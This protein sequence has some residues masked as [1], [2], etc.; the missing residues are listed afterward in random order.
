MSEFK[1]VI[2]DLQEKIDVTHQ[3]EGELT[4]QMADLLARRDKLTAA[5]ESI[6]GLEGG[7]A[8]AR[9]RQARKPPPMDKGA[10]KKVKASTDP[11]EACAGCGREA[12]CRTCDA[13][14]KP[15]CGKCGMKAR[16]K[17]C[18][19][20]HGKEG[21]AP[22]KPAP[23]APAPAATLDPTKLPCIECNLPAKEQGRCVMCGREVCK[24]RC[25]KKFA[26][27]PACRRA[28]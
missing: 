9:G 22:K 12:K 17:T 6:H 7:D 19:E 13:C 3:E 16:A 2:K 21:K 14:E 1:S 10:P 15:K 28:P 27:C 18:R 5:L 20:C 4:A 25:M 11:G 24:D 8:P 26:T 23:A